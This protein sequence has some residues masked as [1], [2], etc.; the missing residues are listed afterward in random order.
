MRVSRS[1]SRVS[2]AAAFGHAGVTWTPASLSP[3]L[4]LDA[5]VGVTV[6]STHV[7]AFADQSGNANNATGSG[8]WTL[9]PNWS[10]GK[11]AL[12]ADGSALTGATKP[13]TSGGACAYLFVGDN[14][15]LGA[16]G[17]GGAPI[18][19]GQTGGTYLA[20]YE[21]FLAGTH[22]IESDG[23]TN[24]TL[25]TPDFAPFANPLHCEWILPAT[26]GVPTH[27]IAGTTQTVAAGTRAVDSGTGYELGV[28]PAGLNWLGHFAEL[29][30]LDR[31]PT[32]LEL[33]SWTN[34]VKAKYGLAS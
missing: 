7:T 15:A 8:G 6:A 30:V 5:N 3:K 29:V 19:V 26:G 12:L 16:G 18:T 28:S 25:A 31:A 17:Q 1:R 2:R 20:L 13:T 4:W 14:P 24:I 21:V 22:Y 10:N 11:S 34:Y 23:T 32:G 9:V 33:A 27:V